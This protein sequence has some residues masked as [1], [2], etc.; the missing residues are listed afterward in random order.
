MKNNNSSNPVQDLHDSIERRK[1]IES[2][3]NSI[4]KEYIEKYTEEYMIEITE[5]NAK[6]SSQYELLD[7]RMKE[8]V[9]Q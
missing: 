3:F 8:I 5:K 6:L 1:I 7:E 9:Q 2:K 4:P